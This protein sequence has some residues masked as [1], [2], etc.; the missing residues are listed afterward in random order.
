MDSTKI[1]VKTSIGAGS[2]APDTVRCLDQ[3]HPELATLGFLKEALRYNC[4]TQII[5]LIK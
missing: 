1:G 2:G 5:K 4:N 3:A